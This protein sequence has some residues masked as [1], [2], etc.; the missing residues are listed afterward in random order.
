M[1]DSPAT[2]DASAASCERDPIWQL[3]R[4][5]TTASPTQS[6]S[7]A[8][9]ERS[10]ART[11]SSRPPPDLEQLLAHAG[12][13]RALACQLVADPERA[14]DV[15]QDT[16]VAALQGG[17]REER[18]VRAWL[19]RV[20]A[21]FAFQ[22]RRSERA[23]TRREQRAASPE[24]LPSVAEMTARAELERRLV[25]EV[26]ALDEPYRATVL[27]CFFE[28]R[29]AAEVARE[30]GVP[31]STVRNR[32]MRAVELLRARIG[33]DERTSWQWCLGGALAPVVTGGTSPGASITGVLAMGVN[34]K[35]AVTLASAAV[36]TGGVILWRELDTTT[37]AK[38]PVHDSAAIESAAA[39]TSDARRRGPDHE[40][41]AAE[42]D[43]SP[44]RSEITTIFVSEILVHGSVTNGAGEPVKQGRIEVAD[45]WGTARAADVTE[46]GTYSVSG[47]PRG[48]WILRVNC[49]GYCE[50]RRDLGLRGDRESVRVDVTLENSLAIAVR[51]IDP[52][53][54]SVRDPLP[55]HQRPP[56]FGYDDTLHAIATRELPGAGTP[57]S[58]LKLAGEF[59][60][61]G[62]PV[63]GAR[64]HVPAGCAGV[65]ELHVPPPAHVSSVLGGIVLETQPVDASTHEV[66]FVI[67]HDELVARMGTLRFRLMNEDRSPIELAGI[68]LLPIADRHWAN[69]VMS[70]LPRGVCDRDGLPPGAFQL[71]IRASG[72][73]HENRVIAIEPRRVTD[74][75]EIILRGGAVLEATVVDENGTPVSLP[76]EWARASERDHPC[77]MP[78]KN[79]DARPGQLLL[80]ELPRD[81][82]LLRIDDPDWAVNPTLVD[83][84]AERTKGL[85][86]TARH[87]T[88]VTIRVR[89]P[90]HAC[91]L[92]IL[93]S[94]GL[95]IWRRSVLEASTFQV[96]LLPGS[97]HLTRRIG[98][99]G[100]PLQ[101]FVVETTSGAIDLHVE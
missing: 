84:S 26:L 73:E 58:D 68:A 63:P 17:P 39:G 49:P 95:E 29:S 34:A 70:P 55:E 90:E 94:S 16:W 92:R 52:A 33:V 62:P 25:G 81:G 99:V 71:Q 74:L 10:P 9:S 40:V 4:E 42:S 15:V 69:P 66:T 91:E 31:S 27:Y 82:V 14:E 21:N 87:G 65:I 50:A 80:A 44:R 48:D 22:H 20:V 6:G 41:A 7:R 11:M 35:L 89:A 24:S 2:I 79:D 61:A 5:A 30:F 72:V 88:P 56:W 75:G 3:A 46:A 57:V 77:Y 53:G 100:V 47:L 96:R 28:N 98:A 8:R 83:T 93:D 54:V 59:T 37:D 51:F 23:R 32:L 60:P 85:T 38:A 12:W 13:V 43:G 18:S 64:V 45:E 19:K 78:Q 86:W 76:V 97:Y 101:E 36:I 67:A 1:S